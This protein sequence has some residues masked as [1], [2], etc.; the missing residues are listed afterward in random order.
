MD[1]KSAAE[2]ARLHAEQQARLDELASAADDLSAA[3]WAR[4]AVSLYASYVEGFNKEWD[5]RGRVRIH[6][7][8]PTTQRLHA[9]QR[10][11]GDLTQ[12]IIAIADDIG[13]VRSRWATD[14]GARYKTLDVVDDYRVEEEPTIEQLS[15]WMD[16]GGCKTPDGCWVEADGTCEH[17]QESWMLIMG[18]I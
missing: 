11:F 17:G 3:E 13:E 2:I 12:Q 15:E 16:D 7:D 14:P 1:A 6:R 8:G 4:D 5:S 10:L 9:A 18:L